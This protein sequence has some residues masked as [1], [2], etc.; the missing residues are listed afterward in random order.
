MPRQHTP[1]PWHVNGTAITAHVGPS[2][3]YVCEV[4][5]SA[6]SRGTTYRIDEHR[7]EFLA[8]AALLATAP[9]LLE[10][11]MDAANE[12]QCGCGHPACRQCQRDKRWHEIIER[13][14]GHNA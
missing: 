7:D 10:E 12:C 9:D 5:T 14:L 11:L 8:N 13:A 3:R 6:P 2:Y 1:G 4:S